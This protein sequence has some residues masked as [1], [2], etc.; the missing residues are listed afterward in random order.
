MVAHFQFDHSE[1]SISL[2]PSA[3]L[4]TLPESAKSSSDGQMCFFEVCF[5]HQI[6]YQNYKIV[7]IIFLKS[8]HPGP[9]S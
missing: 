7:F 2:H 3:E 8:W 9:I 4:L 1:S 6:I 5:L